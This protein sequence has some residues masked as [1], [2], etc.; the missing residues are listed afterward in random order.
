M[1]SASESCCDNDLPLVLRVFIHC[2][3]DIFDCL[4]LKD[5]HSL[6]K[7]CKIIQRVTGEYFQCNFKFAENFSAK[8]GIYTLYSDNKGV[9]NQITQTS[10]FN[11]FIN[12]IPHYYEKMEPLLYISSHSGEFESIRHIYWVCLQ[13]DCEK[14]QYLR[15]IWSKIEYIQINQCTLQGDLYETLLKFC[16]NLKKINLHDDLG[17]ISPKE[18]NAWLLRR[19]PLLEHV[20]LIPRQ[21]FKIDELKTFFKNHPNIRSFSTSSNFLWEN[22]HELFDSNV[23]FDTLEIEIWNKYF[24]FRASDCTPD[25]ISLKSICSL[26]NELHK[27]GFYKRLHFYLK[28]IDQECCDELLSLR[29]LVKLKIKHLNGIYSLPRLTGLKSLDLLRDVNTR[30]IDELAIG[31]ANLEDLYI[32]NISCDDI[33]PFIQHSL[34]LRRIYADINNGSLNLLKLNNERAKLRGA[35]KVTIFVNDNIFLTTKWST[36]NGDINLNFIEMK[37][38]GSHY[39][40]PHISNR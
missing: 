23:K 19:Y 11:Q 8:D 37:R 9:I 30:S 16:V 12:Y 15:D 17:C 28:H 3:N 35:H 13:I 4:S 22:R 33:L 38:M 31:L 5:L 18:N 20:H 24:Y 29:G 7:T 39:N 6:S 34:K 32:K 36:Q 10:G 2:G 26:L 25:T 40:K 14:V 1:A 21:A 27:N